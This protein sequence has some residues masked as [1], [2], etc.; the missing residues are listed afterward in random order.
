[1]AATVP[2]ERARLT[3][4]FRTLASGFMPVDGTNNNNNNKQ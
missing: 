3:I 2:F 1:M 4:P